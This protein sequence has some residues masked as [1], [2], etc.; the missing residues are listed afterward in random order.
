M[1]DIWLTSDLHLGHRMVA[2]LRG[3]DTPEHHDAALA[4]YWNRRVRDDAEV[5]VLG[6]VAMGGWLD[7]LPLL[8]TLPGRKHLVLGNHDRAHPLNRNGHEYLRHF[9]TVFD[10]VQTAAT[11]ALGGSVGRVSLSHF[12][13]EGD[14]GPDR[15]TEWRL[16]DSGRVL[17]HGHTHGTERLTATALG[18]PQLHVGLDAWDLG[19]VH[20]SDALSALQSA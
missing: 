4:A 17:L 8:G 9:L 10:T 18:T 2:N 6:D 20:R 13:Y 5:W 16:R 15:F 3:F 1:P 12:P 11:L 7:R 19:F 14:H